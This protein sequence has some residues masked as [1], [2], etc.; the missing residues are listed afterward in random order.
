M[1]TAR[2][3]LDAD[4]A[5]MMAFWQRVLTWRVALGVI[6][7]LAVLVRMPFLHVPLITDEGG[8]AYTTHYGLSGKTLYHLLWFDRTQGILWVYRVIFQTFGRSIVAIRLFAALYNAGSA[9]L[10]WVIAR[11]L[12]DMRTGL[13][14]A[15]LFALFSAMPH[16]QGFTANAE[17]FMTLPA[18]ASLAFL[19]PTERIRMAPDTHLFARENGAAT[20]RI[21]LSGL[22]AGI[23]VVIKPAEIAAVVVAALLLFRA[24]RREGM[25]WR[26]RL[27]RQSLLGAGVVIGILPAV[28]DGFARDGRAYI[29]QVLLYRGATESII[30]RH[31]F[32]RLALSVWNSL[33]VGGDV[34]PLVILTAL[35]LTVYRASLSGDARR[36]APL[37]FL[38]SF[39]GVALGGNWFTHYF[40]QLLPPLAIYAAIGVRAAFVRGETALWRVRIATVLSLS[41]MLTAA[42]AGRYF[43]AQPAEIAWGLY[44]DRAYQAQ[45]PL[46]TYLKAHSQPNDRIYIAFEAP[47]V[48]YLSERQSAFP[49]VWRQPILND[50]ATFDRLIA[51]L[52]TPTGPEFIVDLDAPHFQRAHDRLR[53]VLEGR[54][55]LA[56]VIQGVQVYRRVPSIWSYPWTEKVDR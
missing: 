56:A 41:V 43:V 2:A 19:L 47:E 8:Y 1:V 49:V 52:D 54:Y 53:P 55:R 21:F 37:W 3:R 48:Y 40:F 16:V 51:T 32:E 45:G 50:P 46:V 11:R 39:G 14:A 4:A 29:Q 20:R 36:L 25:P 18:L 10:V 33:V 17:L 24:A 27:R 23:A 28:V 12:A 34:L 6:L 7:L 31:A 44:H 5:H 13:L 42:Y 38:A 35:A 22:C 15:L 9:L 26:A 30:A